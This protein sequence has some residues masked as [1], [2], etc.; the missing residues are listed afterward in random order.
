MSSSRGV[1]IV[2]YG[3][4]NLTSVGYAVRHLQHESTITRDPDVVRSAERIIFPGVGAAGSAMQNLKELGL[5][6]A[7]SDARRAGT[8]ILG[9]C[10]GCQVI[11][12]RSEEND[13][14]ECL[15]WLGGAVKLFQFAPGVNRKVPHMGWN[16]VHFVRPHAV[17]SDIP[18][19]SQFYFVHS[20]YPAPLDDGAVL[21]STRYG[22][23]RFAA[24][25]GFE[26]VVAV[27]FHAEK[28]GPPGLRLLDN[29][30]RWSPGS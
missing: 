25:L 12:D 5:D 6:S 1:V 9:I 23:V 3:A 28:S 8:P 17:L 11:F 18:D 19:G 10:V 14:T 2:D 27:Q 20:Y 26:N 15:G 4:G 7:L 30:L 24:V 29:F 22:G 16:E 13:G 21:G